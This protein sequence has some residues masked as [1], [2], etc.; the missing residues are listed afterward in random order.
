MFYLKNNNNI[1][2][3]NRFSLSI[4]FSIPSHLFSVTPCIYPETHTYTFIMLS[5]LHSPETHTHINLRLSAER[6][7]H[8]PDA[9]KQG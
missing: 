3:E 7:S 2:F 8:H 4:P 6:S 5:L 9:L 1:G